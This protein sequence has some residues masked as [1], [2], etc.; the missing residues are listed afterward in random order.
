M[1]ISRTLF[2][3]FVLWMVLVTIGS[4]LPSTSFPSWIDSGGK[5]DKIAHFVAYFVTSLLFYLAFRRRFKTIDL[6]AVFFASAYGALIEL[7]QLLVPGRACSFEDLA[8][9]LSGVLFFFVLYRILWGR[10]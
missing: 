1:Q 10:V 9:N 5:G 4:F 7:A 2:I 8:T 3:L 6:Y